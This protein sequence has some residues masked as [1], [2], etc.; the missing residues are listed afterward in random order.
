VGEASHPGPHN[1][2]IISCNIGSM[3]LRKEQVLG[4][5]GSILLCQET[6][7]TDKAKSFIK[8]D[9]QSGGWRCT[10]GKG[11]PG[12]RSIGDFNGRAGGVAILQKPSTIARTFVRS[13]IENSLAQT[14]RWTAQNILIGDTMGTVHC[15]YGISGATACRETRAANEQLLQRI[16]DT[17][18]AGNP[19]KPVIVAGDWNIESENS[20]AISRA[21]QRGILF[22]IGADMDATSNRVPQHTFSGSRGNSSRLDYFL[23]NQK[24]RS[25]VVDVKVL[26]DRISEHWPVQLTLSADRGS[27]CGYSF[28]SPKRIPDQ[29]NMEPISEVEQKYAWDSFAEPRKGDFRLRL[30]NGDVQGAWDL[31]NQVAEDCVLWSASLGTVEQRP[32]PTA[33]QQHPRPPTHCSDN[34]QQRFCISHTLE[35]LPFSGLVHSA[36]E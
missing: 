13:P 24:A 22:D 26:D 7:I 23:V 14:G 10:F 32:A 31:W 33:S 17:A 19:D 27:E 11:V 35:R 20:L 15:V 5:A 12:V 3:S 30:N 8:S 25:M 29:I 34:Q 16:I 2:T 21:R 36:G 9:V 4:L 6:R 1:L 18:V 28:R